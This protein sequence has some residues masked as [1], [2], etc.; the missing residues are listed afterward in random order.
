[1]V[2]SLLDIYNYGKTEV[3]IYFDDTKKLCK[4]LDTHVEITDTMLFQMKQILGEA[5]VKFKDKK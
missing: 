1:M 5:N 3:Y 4:A 2:K